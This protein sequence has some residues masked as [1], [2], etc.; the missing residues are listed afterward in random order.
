MRILP[1]W[2]VTLT[3]LASKRKQR[4]KKFSRRE[5]RM[6]RFESLEEKRVLAT[7]TVDTDSDVINPTDGLTTLR[8]AVAAAAT[9]GDTINFA[10]N[11][12]AGTITLDRTRGQ[13]EIVG[14]SLTID[15]SA[16]S[17]GIT[18]HGNDPNA[19]D[20]TPDR[21]NGNGIR[22]FNITDPTGGLAPPD[23]TMVGLKLTNADPAPGGATPEG[24]AIRS[25]GILTLR[26]MTIRDNGA[27]QGAGVYL[28]VGG[29]GSVQR[30][31]LKIENSRIEHNSSWTHG[32]GVF[33]RFSSAAEGRD[34]VLI[35]GST[36]SNN[37]AGLG[38]TARGRGGGLHITSF[39]GTDQNHAVI[40]SASTFAANNADTGGA[41]FYQPAFN[42]R[43]DL[44][45][46]QGTKLTGNTATGSN[47]VYYAR[48]SGG[49][50]YARAY[51]RS[52]IR[53]EN[54]TI[55]GNTAAIYGSG[56]GIAAIFRQSASIAILDS[57]ISGNTAQRDG[58][59][60]YAKAYVDSDNP[61]P[62]PRAVTLSRSLVSGN[63]ANNRGGGMYAINFSGTE[64]LVED[65]RITGNHVPYTESG[66][67]RN[68]GGI[69]AYVRGNLDGTNTPKWTITRSTVDNNDAEFEGGGIFV[70]SKGSGI[71]VA[72]NTTISGNRTV[73]QSSGAG[74]GIFIARWPPG[75]DDSID[76]YL[77]NVTVTKNTSADGGGVGTA[78]LNN[79]RVRIANSII[80][81][82]VNHQSAPNNLDGRV[83][84]T[85][86]PL[87]LDEFTHNLIGGGSTVR[88]LNGAVVDSTV[89]DDVNIPSD[90][91]LLDEL[92]D[93]GG[94]TPTHRLR[95]EPLD[96][97][98][99][100]AIDAGSNARAT[101]PLTGDPANQND[102][103]PLTTDQ[104]GTEFQ[105]SVNMAGVTLVGKGPVDIGAYEVDSA[106]VCVSKT[107]D[108]FDTDLSDGNLSLREAVNYANTAPD[109]TTIC[110]PE[111]TYVLSLTGLGGTNQGDLDISGNVT[112]V[113]DGAGASIIDASGFGTTNRD[114]VFDVLG[115][116]NLTLSRLTLTG[117]HTR[118]AAGKHGGAIQVANTGT[119]VL[120]QS[121]LVNNKT[122]SG[123]NGGGIYFAASGS[124][125]ILRSVITTDHADHLS[126]GIY[127]AG[128]APEAGGTVTVT[129]TIVVNNSDEDGINP[130]V[131][132]DGNR[133]F[134]S[135]GKN[136]LGNATT[137]FV[138]GQQGD[139][140]KPAGTTVHYVVTSVV[141][142]YDG[143]S[144]PTFMSL[145][146]AIHQA[147][148]TAGPQEIWLPAW[149]FVLTVARSGQET[150]TSVEYG[151]LDIGRD[152]AT[153]PGGSVTIRGINGS[154]SVGWAA[155]LP[156]DKV[157]ELLGDY[158]GDG[159]VNAADEL[160]LEKDVPEADGDE[161][162]DWVDDPD[163]QN[164]YDW[165]L[166][167]VLML[168]GIIVG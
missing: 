30:D 143:F 134:T 19:D 93:N 100:P 34:K 22:I 113:G 81:Q 153:D 50:L 41:I 38:S 91:P 135:G 49:G 26:N 120:D 36:I 23:V 119:L 63:T 144:D 47:V 6:L 11:L 48:G 108:E 35:T 8:E 88:Y 69:Y 64:T 106:L 162:G 21:N 89:W 53:V 17:S 107:S 167:W 114:R 98:V 146:D 166:N 43:V 130:D 137:G 40:I 151:D 123:G 45:L 58:G 15:A 82:N 12:N 46:L 3:K 31:V 20:P 70:C 147:N 97:V 7:I 77:R 139:Y 51:G 52:Q 127:L 160:V 132:A 60:V 161:D 99:S 159:A 122:E 67:F 44:S 138:D 4:R 29:N 145:R 62:T 164:L 140:I 148:I 56:G 1:D 74:G 39:S 131:F 10:S 66:S 103:D 54:A 141:D 118:T 154:T 2:L 14:K 72:T 112:I 158:N 125:T 96:S 18:I 165:N 83:Y 75:A 149:N 128:S 142:T 101:V 24:G 71:F 59:G 136:R 90:T 152:A 92:E 155:G 126:G 117:G 78:N 5:H 133:T 156:S 9:T 111:G 168:D 116:A 76:A 61:F 13:I 157:F 28:A 87:N 121:A 94:S 25:A 129:E 80:S 115:S 84:I 73:N 124:G 86:S 85:Q 68:G 109:P 105:R 42:S 65:S 37:I 27:G 33:V 57:T 32:G 79:V 104:R 102:D 163:D 150:D 95:Y 55:S 16:L 110:L